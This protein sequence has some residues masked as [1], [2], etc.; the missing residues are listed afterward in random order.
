MIAL[1]VDDWLWPR[2]RFAVEESVHDRSQ[3]EQI[4][5]RR[6]TTLAIVLGRR[7]RFIGIIGRLQVCPLGWNEGTA[8]V[9]KRDEQELNATPS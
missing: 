4:D 2:Y 6:D 9:R 3:V 7:Q 1:L 5:E 8:A